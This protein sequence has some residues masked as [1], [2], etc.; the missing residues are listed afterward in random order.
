MKSSLSLWLDTF[1][2]SLYPFLLLN[3]LKE[4]VTGES[5]CNSLPIHIPQKKLLLHI[6]QMGFFCIEMYWVVDNEMGKLRKALS[7]ILKHL[8]TLF[9]LD[10]WTG[11]LVVYKWVQLSYS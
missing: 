2:D 7:F 9:Y 5:V 1:T 6:Q 10:H 4:E 11:L 8:I 3:K